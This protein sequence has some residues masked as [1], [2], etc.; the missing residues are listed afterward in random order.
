MKI[1]CGKIAMNIMWYDIGSDAHQTNQT[2]D[3]TW[4]GK[5]FELSLKMDNNVRDNTLSLWNMWSNMW[6][7]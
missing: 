7:H 5:E 6:R 1:G 3:E 4:Y 2:S